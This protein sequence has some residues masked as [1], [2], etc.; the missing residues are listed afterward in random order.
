MVRL[1]GL[2]PATYG[3]EVRHSIQLSYKRNKN[4]ILILGVSEGTRTLN[5]RD[6]NPVL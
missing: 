4:Y 1:A 5:P 2:E 3:S 6:H